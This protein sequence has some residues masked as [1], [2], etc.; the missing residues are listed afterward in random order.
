MPRALSERAAA[1]QQE[2][3]YARRLEVVRDHVQEP[4]RLRELR[5]ERRQE[6]AQRVVAPDARAIRRGARAPR[7]LCDARHALRD[8]EETADLLSR[9]GPK[10]GFAD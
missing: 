6:P 4:G 5:R 10:A 1:D 8:G 3:M 2:S 7:G 9:L